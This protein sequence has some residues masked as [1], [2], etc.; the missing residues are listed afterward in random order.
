MTGD[1]GPTNS[2]GQPG[3]VS[4]ALS[5]LCPRCGGKSLFEAPAR[6][7]LE[8]SQCGLKFSEFERGGRFAGL[9]T[10]AVAALLITVA[11][12]I[13]NAYR[14]PLLL[15]ALI[16]APVTITAV[17]GT[18]RLYKTALLYA[19]YDKVQGQ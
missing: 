19:R 9:V 18:L 10:M 13:E 16:W 4:A 6:I 5:G 17:L 15:Q 1:H 14:P 3:I 8:C 12:V 7:A 11:M 2:K